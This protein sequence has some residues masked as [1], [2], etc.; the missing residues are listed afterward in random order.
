MIHYFTRIAS[1]VLAFGF[2][3]SCSSLQ[4]STQD[5]ESANKL[6]KQQ[7][8]KQ[9][10]DLDK[11]ISSHPNESDLY[12]ERGKL[13]TKLAQK[14]GDPSQRVSHYTNARSNFDKAFELYQDSAV[15]VEKINDL[16]N[17]SWSHEHNKGVEL[18]QE[19]SP[20]NINYSR[21]AD[22]FNNATILIPD[23]AN[24]Y[25]MKARALYHNQ[26]AKEAISTLEKA[27]DHINP[28]PS[29]LLEQLAFL[30]LQNNDP[31]KAINIYEEAESFSGQNLNLLHGLANAY[32]SAEEHSKAITILEQLIES[33]PRNIIYGQSLA[34]ELY[35]VGKLELDSIAKN[36]DNKDI[37]L[38]ETNFDSVKTL[39]T[40]AEEQ[41]KWIAEANPNDQE[42]QERV[43]QFHYNSASNYHRLVTLV[44]DKHRDELQKL[45]QQHLSASIPL[46]EKIVEHNQANQT[47]WEQLY[48]AY[49]ILGMENKA[50]NAKANIKSS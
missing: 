47:I 21:A 28:P 13:L 5:S 22:H 18:L 8:E 20:E 7:I 17:V 24:S 16:L 29:L 34:T 36:I 4:P 50:E 39:L 23:S 1:L 41:F 48:R 2:F 44:Q 35:H 46:L 31:R 33:E 10:E 11:K 37:T 40:K 49:S 9:L 19:E 6:S 32:I 27:K 45:V 26:Q 43:A 14:N 38:E 12:F 3:I 42:I 25:T 30:Y 15:N